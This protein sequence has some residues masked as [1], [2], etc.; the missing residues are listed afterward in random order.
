M[1][2]IGDGANDVSMILEADVGVGVSGREGRH[3]VMAS[4]FSLPSFRHL[5]RL[6]L[7]HGHWSYYRNATFVLYYLYK[8]VFFCFVLF[9]F[10]LHNGFS[11][12]SAIDAW[13]LIFASLMYTSLPA[14]VA[15]VVDRDY[16]AERLLSCPGLYGWGLRGEGYNTRL[17]LWSMAEMA[18]QSV[19]VFYVT[20]GVLAGSGET[21]LWSFGVPQMAAYVFVANAQLA[22]MVTSI[23]W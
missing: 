19:V 9:W 1:L 16:S 5:S 4:D 21:E 13:N 22:L 18:L 20:Y 8:N 23:P 14:I 10:M 15:A 11:G 17:F 6:L 3:A 2:A 7:V 12:Q